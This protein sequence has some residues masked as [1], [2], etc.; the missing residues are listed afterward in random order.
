MTKTSPP[1][2][3]P[4]NYRPISL[5]STVSKLLKKDT[6]HTFSESSFLAQ[7]HSFKSVWFY[8]STINALISAC[9]SILLFL[10]SSSFVCGVFLNIR[11]AFDSIN[12]S[13][14]LEK[15]HSIA[16]PPNIYAWLSS[17]LERRNQSVCVGESFSTPHPVLSGVPQGSILGPLF[18]TAFLNEIIFFNSS[19]AT[20]LFLYADD[21]LLLH[22]INNPVD[23][24]T[25]NSKLE[26]ISSWLS[27]KLL[28]INTSKLLKYMYFPL[29][30]Q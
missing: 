1:S 26:T 28:H 14:L 12:H 2:A 27:S 17:Y 4:S 5:F 10:N 24:L 29:C 30:S 19:F 16:L 22:P 15:L 21:I 13:A 11:K 8:S 25:L 7:S 18:F 6:T 9:H 20:S 23:I 3:T